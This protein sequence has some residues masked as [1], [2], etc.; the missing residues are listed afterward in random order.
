[1]EENAWTFTTRAVR[2]PI[3]PLA[4]LGFAAIIVAGCAAPG[5]VATAAAERRAG[6]GRSGGVDRRP[7][8]VGRRDG[9]GL[10]HRA[11]SR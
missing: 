2:P 3:R 8:R 11:R 1:M 7:E 10:R 4:T 6:D 9:A 5:A